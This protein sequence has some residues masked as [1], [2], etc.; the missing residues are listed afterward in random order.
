M[1]LNMKKS[2]AMLAGVAAITITASAAH[3]DGEVNIYSSRHYDTDERLYSDFTETTGIKVNRIEA[4]ASELLERLKAEGA[5]S[6]A[7][8]VLTV[9]AGRL[10][11]FQKEDLFQSVNSAKLNEAIPANL[12]DNDG[13]WYGISQRAR[14]IFYD[15]ASVENPPQT[16]ADLADP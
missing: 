12:R 5:N 16:Y 10:W 11:A 4:G 14:V 9:D 6:P 13:N 2:L 7:D 15:K 8:V 1:S 3:A